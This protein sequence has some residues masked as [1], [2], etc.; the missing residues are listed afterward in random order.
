MSEH[1]ARPPSKG[2][3]VNLMHRFLALTA[4]LVLAGACGGDTAGAE[5][6]CEVARDMEDVEPG[7]VEATTE[8]FQ[9][10]R[11]EAPDDIRDAVNTIVDASE[12]AFETR[13][14]TV[15]QREEVMAA[16]DEFDAYLEENCEPPE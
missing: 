1:A 13:D 2:L 4:I 11:E 10:L 14:A 8:V 16:S 12:E 6:F 9:R 3:P 15:L 7:D 5:A